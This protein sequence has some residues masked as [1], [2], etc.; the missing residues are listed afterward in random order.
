MGVRLLGRLV[1]LAGRSGNVV[2]LG[3]RSHIRCNELGSHAQADRGNHDRYEPAESKRPGAKAPGALWHVR[4]G[5]SAPARRL[6]VRPRYRRR[7]AVE[8][9]H[10]YRPSVAQPAQD[11]T[12][13]A[14][15]GSQD[16][17]TPGHQGNEPQVAFFVSCGIEA[18]VPHTRRCARRRT[19]QH[20]TDV[21]QLEVHRSPKPKAVGSSP[22]VRAS[23]QRE[24][25]GVPDPGPQ[26][27]L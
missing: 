17:H 9:V 8:P 22:T 11:L 12:T 25:R 27:G 13:P 18:G 7:M 26:A 4:T 15:C 3:G 16:P 21:A 6:D 24:T 10:R 1:K 14:P 5:A 2:A 20:R 23:T 19:T